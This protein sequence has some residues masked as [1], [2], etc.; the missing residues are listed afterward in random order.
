VLPTR[1]EGW[2][3]HLTEAMS[4]EM[5]IIVTR[6]GGHLDFMNENNS[7]L[8]NID[9]TDSDGFAIPN[10]NH[11]KQLMRHVYKNKKDA[12]QKGRK[13]R[14]CVLNDYTWEQCCDRIYDRLNN[15]S[16]EMKKE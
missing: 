16:S 8:I 13:A 5:P 11:L 12:T 10:L 7:Y 9:G 14:E 1:G 6:W 15:V 3:L 2:G 4:M